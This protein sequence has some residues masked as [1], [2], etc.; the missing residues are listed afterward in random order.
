MKA[1]IIKVFKDGNRWCA[2]I[3]ENLQEG[4]AGFAKNPV[5]AVRDL[6]D[7]LETNLYKKFFK[8]LKP[9]SIYHTGS[10]DDIICIKCS[11]KERW[12]HRF[13]SED[14]SGWNRA[15]KAGW[16]IDYEHHTPDGDVIVICPDH[17]KKEE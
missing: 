16:I 9:P 14:L 7:K 6:C 17:N 4:V 10:F 5:E 2:L 8:P 13:V 3:G 15:R 12:F 1:R 11:R